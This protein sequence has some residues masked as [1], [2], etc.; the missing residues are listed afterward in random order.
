MTATITISGRRQ[1]GKTE[2]VIDHMV[3]HAREGGRVAYVGDTLRSAIDV[4]RRIEHR[5]EPGMIK[6]Y[7]AN[8]N[9][10]ILFESGGEIRFLSA[11]RDSGRGLSLDVLVWDNV[12]KPVSPTMECTLTASADPRIYRTVL[13]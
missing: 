4:Q 8:G 7:R 13:E 5:D 10:R 1:T 2:A 12:N 3:R 11:G 9:E 6:S